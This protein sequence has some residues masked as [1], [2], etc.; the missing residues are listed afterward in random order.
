MEFCDILKTV[1]V[2]CYL[3]ILRQ[4]VFQPTAVQKGMISVREEKRTSV[5]KIILISVAVAIAIVG[6]IALLYFLFKKYFKVSIDCG[7]CDDCEDSCFGDSF[8]PLCD[9]DEDYVPACNL[10]DA[11]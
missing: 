2:P 7:D 5:L 11:E 4:K 9:C 10:D 3:V 8:D 6:I 1:G